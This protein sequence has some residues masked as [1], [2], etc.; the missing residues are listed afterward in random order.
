[1]KRSVL[2][3]LVC[4]HCKEPLELRAAREDGAEVMEG[5]LRAR[6][7]RSFPI[8]RGVPRF[9]EAGAYASSFGFQWNRF[10]EVQL[11]SRS[12][13]GISERTLAQTTGW[14]QRDYEGRLVLDAGVGA[15][16]FAEVAA[17]KGGEVI[18]I[19]LTSAVDAAFTS[20][21]RHERVHLCQAD[22]FAMPFRP[23]SF[24]LAYSIGVLH[25]TPDPPAAFARVAEAVKPGGGLAVYL[26]AAYGPSHRFS[27]A[28]RRLTT[29]LPLPLMLRLATVAIPL[30]YVY[31]VPLVG[32]ALNTVFPI[33]MDPDWRWRWLDTFDWYTPKYQFKYRY[34]EVF[35]WFRAAGFDDVEVFDDPIRMR[36]S[37]PRRA[38]E[39]AA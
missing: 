15:G 26:Y 31:R 36:G 5:A 21:G 17:A 16:R 14:T 37:K 6:C 13:T 22:I 30:Y 32:G 2:K 27:D 7:G 24:D 34:P 23:D 25:H 33:C 8:L 19:D 1:M 29:R 9:V 28:I 10:R 39:S 18:G 12:G 4:P 20:I 38:R 3:H 11:D 35:R